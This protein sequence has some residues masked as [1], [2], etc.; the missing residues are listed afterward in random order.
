[1]IVTLALLGSAGAAGEVAVPTLTAR[2]TDQT[3]TLTPDQI[4]SIGQTLEAFEARKGTQIAVLIVPTTEPETIEQYS[5][6]VVEQWK[7][8]RRQVDDGALL[9]VAK[10]DRT[11][12]IEVGYGL[13]GALNDA[14]SNRIIR[15]TIIPRF[16][17]NDFYGGIAAGVDQMIRVADGEPLPPPQTRTRGGSPDVW[18]L[19]PVIFMLAVALAGVL[20]S[21]FGR[22]P[23]AVI[24]GGGAA[25][26]AWLLAT[27]IA[28][29]AAAG[30]IAFLFTLFGTGM[31]AYVG[32]YGIGH[33]RGGF[34]RG[35]RGGFGGGGGSFG[36]GGA[37][38]RW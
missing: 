7:L 15:E 36:G 33:H 4:E 31:G 27:G 28:A 6:R 23:G 10:N 3:A 12:R 30:L 38:G 9:I 14:I 21:A 20:R 29:V 11:L 26:I 22:L 8:G 18:K 1:M 17:E 24:A 25:L 5:L 34:G 32:T 35:G 16:R 2:V 13:E 19:A 37:S